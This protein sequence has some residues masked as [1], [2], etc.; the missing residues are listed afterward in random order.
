MAA[1]QKRILETKLQSIVTV[2][3]SIEEVV[4]ETG[5]TGKLESFDKIVFLEGGHKNK[6]KCARGDQYLPRVHHER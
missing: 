2:H 5:L 4:V 1:L 6:N 3:I